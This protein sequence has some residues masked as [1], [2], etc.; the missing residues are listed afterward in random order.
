[1]LIR[2]GAA[3]VL[4]PA[5]AVMRRSAVGADHHVVGRSKQLSADRTNVVFKR[6]IVTIL[7]RDPAP[8][9]AFAGAKYYFYNYIITAFFANFNLSVKS[10][11]TFYK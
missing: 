7:C 3:A 2:V 11:F 5:G 8:D 10:F 6:H 1:M 9:K 4:H